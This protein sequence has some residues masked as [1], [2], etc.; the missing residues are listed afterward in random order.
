MNGKTTSKQKQSVYIG[1]GVTVKK[2]IAWILGVLI[3]LN[4]VAC[5]GSAVARTETERQGTAMVL[6]E[7]VQIYVPGT[8]L[9]TDFGS[10]TVMDAAFCEKAQMYYTTTSTTQK[11]TVNGQTTENYQE[12]IEPGYLPMM[13]DKV[14]FALKAILTNSSGADLPLR[15]LKGQAFFAENTAIYF[16]VGGNYEISDAAYSVLPDGSSGEYILAALVPVAQYQKTD[17]CLLKIGGADLG[18]TLDNVHC[19]HSLGFQPEDNAVSSMAQILQTA[20]S[21]AAGDDSIDATETEAAAVTVKYY[22]EAGELV[23]VDSVSDLEFSY[24]ATNSYNGTVTRMRYYYKAPSGAT[25]ALEMIDQYLN[26]LRE[27]GYTVSENGIDVE[28]SLDGRCLAS[29]VI[30]GT[31]VEVGIDIDRTDSEETNPR[32]IRQIA[33]GDTIALDFLEMKI[34]GIHRADE[35]R[36]DDGPNTYHQGASNSNNQMFW[37]E[38]TM[39]NTGTSTF[40]IW[41]NGRYV[42]QIVFDDAY[43]YEAGMTKLV[44]MGSTKLTPMESAKVYIYAEIPKEML[45]RY[46]NVRIRFGFNDQFERSATKEFDDMKNRFEFLS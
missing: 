21:N 17:S 39:K 41:G 12:T 11:T 23:T 24:S 1:E 25:N 42:A 14:I 35:I 44:G 13:E 6:A 43:T 22:R 7:D 15:E 45:D 32:A 46:S 27:H 3:S 20:S 33:T 36:E 9:T 10:I 34:A 18:V 19:Y 16:S 4:C 38:T 31:T 26:Y 40:D 28:V 5:G 8:T 2:W 37:L 29:I 30:M